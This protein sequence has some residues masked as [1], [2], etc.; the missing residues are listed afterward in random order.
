MS[1]PERDFKAFAPT[2]PNW[3]VDSEQAARKAWFALD[4]ADQ[5]QAAEKAEAYVEQVKALKANLCSL[6]VYLREKRWQKITPPKPADE[7]VL[8]K[9]YGKAWTAWRLHLLAQPRAVWRPTPFQKR[10]ID[11]GR[12]DALVNDR[13]RGEFPA[14]S[15]LDAQAATNRAH[16]VAAGVWVPPDTSDYHAVAVGSAE[17]QTWATWHQAHDYPFIDPPKFVKFVWFPAKF[18]SLVSVDE[19]ADQA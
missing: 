3:L 2:W 1:D 16:V 10:M 7:P 18:F 14:V 11:A 5:Q 8:M 17:W 6:G 9:P 12:E 4:E 15:K 13:L 19:M